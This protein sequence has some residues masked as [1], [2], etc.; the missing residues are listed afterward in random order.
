VKLNI[1]NFV[2][3]MIVP[4]RKQGHVIE[5]DDD[6]DDESIIHLVTKNINYIFYL[7]IYFYIY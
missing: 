3:L 4:K 5:D 1:S 7:S 2:E 6:D